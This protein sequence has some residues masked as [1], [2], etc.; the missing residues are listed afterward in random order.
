MSASKKQFLLGALAVIV[1]LAA[2]Q[3]AQPTQNPVDIEN[4]VATSVA[5]TVAA[6][7]AQTQAAVPP[8]AEPTNTTLPTQ[9]AEG[10]PSPTLVATLTAVPTATAIVIPATSV[11]GGGGGGT[12]TRP[13]YRCDTIR[14]RPF[15]NT[16]FRPGDRFDIKWTII[17]TGTKTMVAGL[18]LKYNTGTQMTNRTRVELPELKPGAEFAVD[19]DAVAPNKEGT[20]IMTFLVEGGLCYPY[21]AIIVEK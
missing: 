2:C 8:T 1:L 7:N 16:S 14:R 11:S 9:T 13:E 17:N 15:D 3:P 5:L 21:V 18:D 19:F 20:Y 4:E 12:T 6:Q 10:V